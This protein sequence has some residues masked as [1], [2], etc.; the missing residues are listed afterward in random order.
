MFHVVSPNPCVST[1]MGKPLQHFYEFQP[2]Y[3]DYIELALIFMKMCKKSVHASQA[4]TIYIFPRLYLHPFY[5]MRYVE[6]EIN[7]IHT[8]FEDGS[9]KNIWEIQK[10]CTQMQPGGEFH[11]MVINVKQT[12]PSKKLVIFSKIDPFRCHYRNEVTDE[13]VHLDVDNL[14]RNNIPYIS[15]IRWKS[16]WENPPWELRNRSIL[17]SFTGS[18]FGTQA[19]TSIRKQIYELCKPPQ[20]KAFV[21]ESMASHKNIKRALQ[22]KKKSVFCLEPPGFS[23]P[24]RSMIDSILSGCIPVFFMHPRQFETYLPMHYHWDNHSYIL[25]SPNQIK[26][27]F[28][29]LIQIQPSRI[30][31]MQNSIAEHA[32]SLVYGID[33]IPGD[34][35][36]KI[37]DYFQLRTTELK[38][39]N[40]MFKGL[41][42]F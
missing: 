19:S 13:C 32:T 37:I 25:F 11:D 5:D 23:P 31:N 24:R 35:V 8:T 38:K 30:R 14:G 7:K 34:A 6:K 21:R 1:L 41:R 20:C 22:I 16:T 15:N 26:S 12:Y 17:V 29:M 28:T 10:Y 2:P 18:L 40:H 27:L 42:Y 39:Q 3:G 33:D 4:S 36:D 9:S